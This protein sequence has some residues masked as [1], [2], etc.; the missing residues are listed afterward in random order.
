MAF[1]ILMSA[2]LVEQYATRRA[3][4]T[5]PSWEATWMIEPPPAAAMC[6]TAQRLMRK[7]PPTLTAN[8]RVQVARSTSRT[9]PPGSL[10]AAAF[11]STCK[12]P[13]ALTAC[14][15]A[16]RVSD[17]EATSQRSARKSAFSWTLPRSRSRQATFAP[18]DA[19]AC[20]IAR[21]MPA[22]AP[23][24]IAVL[25]LREFT[26]QVETLARGA[27][28]V[29]EQAPDGAIGFFRDP[30]GGRVDDA[31]ARVHQQD[32][33][34]HQLALGAE[35]DAPLDPALE[36]GSGFT[37]ARM[38]DELRRHRRQ[39]GGRE[40]AL[41]LRHLVA[42]DVHRVGGGF[43]HQVDHVLAGAA[44]VLQAVLHRAVQAQVEAEDAERRLLRDAV[45]EGEGGAVGDTVLAPGGDPADRTRDHQADEEL[46]A[47]LRRQA[48]QLK[49]HFSPA[50]PRRRRARR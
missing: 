43:I 4:P 8:T 46:V 6:G 49:F 41:A 1:A 45:E 12:P 47:L 28:A 32:L 34:D 9:V 14:S 38:L 3:V 42:G 21:P 33:A 18:A 50:S 20:A 15:T 26:G 29:G 36:R 11:T 10:T 7:A 16:C 13:R 19:K 23:V 35:L 44:D 31:V 5:D 30:L 2:P 40:L 27:V 48:C 39:A 25:S 24:T 37:D 17:S 22:P